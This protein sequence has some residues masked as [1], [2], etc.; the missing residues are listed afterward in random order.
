MKLLYSNKYETSDWVCRAEA[1]VYG[2]EE[3][4]VSHKQTWINA[5]FYEDCKIGKEGIISVRWMRTI[6]K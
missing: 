4:Y 2:N 3:D 6:K 5:G 1:H